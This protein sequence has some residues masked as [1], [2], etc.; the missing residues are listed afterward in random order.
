VT[1]I[2][3]SYCVVDIEKGLSDDATTWDADRP[4]FEVILAA[5]AKALRYMNNIQTFHWEIPE[6]FMLF[7]LD[8]VFD[9]LQ[10]LCCNL[11]D[12]FV[13]YGDPKDYRQ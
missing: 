9:V 10:T 5:F 6:P 13:R 12:L 7:S 11:R 1:C 4:E 8:T 3:F 2:I